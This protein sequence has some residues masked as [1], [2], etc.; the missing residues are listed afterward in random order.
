[1]LSSGCYLNQEARLEIIER[2]A[3]VAE[4]RADAD[5]AADKEACAGDPECLREA[6]ERYAA[7]MRQV[8]ATRD[9]RVDALL[10]DSRGGR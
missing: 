6:G 1:M 8:Q 2:E 5:F 4:A 7:A 9:A 10:E 3:V